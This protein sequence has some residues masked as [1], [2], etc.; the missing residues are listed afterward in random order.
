MSLENIKIGRE[1]NIGF[2]ADIIPEDNDKIHY[3]AWYQ[4]EKENGIKESG[5]ASSEIS[6]EDCLIEICKSIKV[7]ETYNKE[8]K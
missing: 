7:M 6:I 5:V 4:L 3:M 8:K 1:Y 2:R